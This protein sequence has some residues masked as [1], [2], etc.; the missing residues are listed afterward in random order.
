MR[1]LI[2]EQADLAFKTEEDKNMSEIYALLSQPTVAMPD[3]KAADVGERYDPK[4]FLEVMCRWPESHRFPREL[5]PSLLDP[6]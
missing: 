3:T 1:V 2:C 5:V 6:S 4:A